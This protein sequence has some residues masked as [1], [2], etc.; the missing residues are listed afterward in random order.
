MDLK[1]WAGGLPK[2][3]KCVK[4]KAKCIW[5]VFMVSTNGQPVEHL[6]AKKMSLPMD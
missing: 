1:V 4:K 5:L 3:K 2:D 6:L